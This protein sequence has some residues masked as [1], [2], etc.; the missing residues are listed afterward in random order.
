MALQST[1][2]GRAFNS[3]LKINQSHYWTLTLQWYIIMLY[4][5]R[6]LEFFDCWIHAL[7]W[8]T[9]FRATY[10]LFCIIYYPSN[11]IIFIWR[12]LRS[13]IFVIENFQLYYSWNQIWKKT[14]NIQPNAKV[15][16]Q[17]FILFIVQMILFLPNITGLNNWSRCSVI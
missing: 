11:Y 10:L 7:I 12:L 13:S 9:D 3:T 17:N 14:L 15:D 1:L 16:S 5:E 2:S 6:R 8:A 4:C